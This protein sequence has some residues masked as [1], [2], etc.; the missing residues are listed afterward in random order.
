ME[1]ALDVR[2]ANI[3]DGE[4]QLHG[5]SARYGD[6]Q[7]RVFFRARA[8]SGN[9]YAIPIA[10]DAAIAM[11][12]AGRSFVVHVDGGSRVAI[13]IGI[14]DALIGINDA[15]RLAPPD[16]TRRDSKVSPIPPAAGH[17]HRDVG[18]TA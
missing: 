18:S 9:L 4:I 14:D 10:K 2:H 3:T 12:V 15:E 16:L 6:A 7:I 1:I 8:G 17:L 5:L 13:Q 11:I